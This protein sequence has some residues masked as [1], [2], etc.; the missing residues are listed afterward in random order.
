MVPTT[1]SSVR[2]NSP[3]LAII[4]SDVCRPMK[5]VFTKM[6]RRIAMLKTLC[7]VNSNRNI[8]SWSFP[9]STRCFSSLL[10]SKGPLLTQKVSS[11]ERVALT[12]IVPLCLP[13]PLES[14]GERIFA[15]C[16]ASLNLPVHQIHYRYFRFPKCCS[17]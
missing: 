7:S 17:C 2:I 9:D 4:S 14:S 3:D 5:I 13:R 8:L 10:Q 15:L 12:S 6:T 1:S 16:D 11:L